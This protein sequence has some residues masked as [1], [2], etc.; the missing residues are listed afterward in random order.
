MQL[1]T[2]MTSQTKRE[3]KSSH[4]KFSDDITHNSHKQAAFIRC[5]INE[6]RQFFLIM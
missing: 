6:I 5:E 2:H 1:N 3:I 4:S